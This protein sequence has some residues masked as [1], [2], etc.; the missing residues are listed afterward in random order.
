MKLNINIKLVQLCNLLLSVIGIL[1]L[2]YN[3]DY[4]Y[5]LISLFSFLIFGIVGV[6]AGYHRYFSHRSYNTYRPVVVIM[7]LLGTLSTLGS[8]ISWVAIHRYHHLHADK[9]EDPHS[10]KFIGW[11][12]AYTYNWLRTSISKKFIRDLIGD[13]LVM[14]L[15]R[16]YYKVILTYIMLLAFIDPWLIIFAY[17]IPC[18]GCLNGV[19]AVTVI[20]HIH[21][22]KN[23]QHYD[24]AKNS[25][26]ATMFSLGEGWHNNHHYRPYNWKQ[27]EKF[28]E[29]DPPSWFISLIK[30]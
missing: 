22:Y 25:W 9:P 7:A 4:N 15:H 2:Y 27:G 28:W 11:W 6:N 3:F 23:H 17:A 16:H 19:S 18:T 10:P 8:L 29:I 24:E 26:I 20:S 1:Y 12:N 5:V 30:K 13:P 14:F 21:G